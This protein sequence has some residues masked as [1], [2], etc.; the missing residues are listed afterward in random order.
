MMKSPWGGWFI[1]TVGSFAILEFVA[2]SNRTDTLSEFLARWS[3]RM[4][5]LAPFGFLAFWLWLTLH[6]IEEKWTRM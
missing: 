1:A 3:R 2:I 4:G 5:P 6:V